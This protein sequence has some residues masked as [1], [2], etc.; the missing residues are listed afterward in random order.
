MIRKKLYVFLNRSPQKKG[1]S[2]V[3]NI[4][5]MVAIAASIIPLTFRD[6][7]PWF[8]TVEIITVSFF[9]LDYLLRWVTAD[10]KLRKGA[11]SF[12]IYPFTPMAIVDLLSMMPAIHLIGSGFKVFRLTRLLRILRVFKFLRYSDKVEVFLKV[13]RKERQVLLSVL[14]IAIFYVFVT[15]LL[16][17]NTE[18][19]FNPETGEETFRHFFDALYW[20]TVTLTTVGYGDLCPV[21]D[22]GRFV[23]MMS[24][25][26][27][28]AIIAL[29]SG[30][31]TASYLEELRNART[32]KEE[33][34]KRLRQLEAGATK[35]IP[36]SPTT[37]R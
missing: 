28:V 5:M 32:R 14:C 20:A 3:Y 27:G 33:K 15:A 9:L 2:Q 6:F 37:P 30:V 8:K 12:L 16:M 17:F 23:S 36:D 4:L 25:I 35:K 7:H 26:F 18:P 24:S 22:I 10:Y 34:E 19:R 31:I 1:W 29:P 13:I 11:L 21:T